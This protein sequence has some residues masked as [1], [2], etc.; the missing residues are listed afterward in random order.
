MAV[1]HAATDSILIGEA[2][3]ALGGGAPHRGIRFIRMPKP[4]IV[5]ELVRTH[6]IDE[7]GCQGALE[8]DER[9][10]FGEVTAR[11]SHARASDSG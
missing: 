8:L 11:R 7:I 5:S 10:S 1:N 9:R 6:V 3:L 4:Q 2:V